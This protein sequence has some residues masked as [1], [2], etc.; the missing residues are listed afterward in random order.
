[1]WGQTP[2]VFSAFW[3]FVHYQWAVRTI[4]AKL[5][6][7]SLWRSHILLF[8]SL[9]PQEPCSVSSPTPWIALY[10]LSSTYNYFFL[11][12]GGA[13]LVFEAVEHEEL[14]EPSGGTNRHCPHQELIQGYHP[15]QQGFVS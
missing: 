15:D 11:F 5:Q 2:P 9:G 3:L 8:S 13:A 6:P 12:L 10:S 14:V 4:L 1:M 7:E